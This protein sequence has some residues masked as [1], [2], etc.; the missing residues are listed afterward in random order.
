[1][2]YKHLHFDTIDST[3]LEAKRLIDAGQIDSPTVIV[4]DEQ[5]GGKGRLGRSWSSP[6]GNLYASVIMPYEAGL[7]PISAQITSVALFEAVQHVVPSITDLFIKWPN[8]L[9][10][11][12]AKLSGILVEVHGDQIVIGTG[13][14]VLHHPNLAER[15]T[16]SLSDA[17]YA[18]SVNELLTAYLEKLTIYWQQGIAGQMDE[19][20][21]KWRKCLVHKPGDNIHVRLPD[22]EISGQYAGV[23]T[24]GRVRLTVDGEEHVIAAGDVF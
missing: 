15:P 11:N 17:G 8:D 23:D 2:P 4:A 12:Q 18:V 24:A 13:V 5:T 9:L 19:I 10:L 6:K 1:M 21:V 22:R 16:I 20:L 14:N 3:N 7:A